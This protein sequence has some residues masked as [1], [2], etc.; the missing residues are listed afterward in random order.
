MTRRALWA[1]VLA[2][3]AAAGAAAIVAGS[4]WMMRGADSGEAARAPAA[5]SLQLYCQFYV[6]TEQRPRVGFLFAVEGDG[7]RP[8]FRQ[9][10]V[11]E[12]NGERTDFDGDDRPEWRLERDARPP[13]IVSRITVPDASQAARHEE[14]IAIEM[15]GYEPG[16]D[17]TQ[18]FEASLKNVH[19]QNLPGKCRQGRI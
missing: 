9:L 3:A 17:S 4:H 6:F 15:Y 11:A 19:Y 5:R 16:R 12:D 14:D 10:Y 1:G 8:A 2:A 18:W 7:A 13:R